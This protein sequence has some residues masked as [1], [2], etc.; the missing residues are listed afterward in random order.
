[1]VPSVRDCYALMN[2]YG[3][4]DNIRDHSVLVAKVAGL[5]SSRLMDAGFCVSME[6]TIAGALLHDIGKTMCL[7]YG[8]DHAALGREICLRHKF[9]EIADIVGEHVRLQDHSAQQAVSEKEIVYYADKRVTHSSVVSLEERLSYILE[10][11]GRN[12]SQICQRIR[13]NFALCKSLEIK[14]FASLDFKPEDL[15]GII[16]GEKLQGIDPDRSG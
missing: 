1:M 4:L 2:G 13:E 10:Q 11:Y 14:L 16:E 12:S 5:I 7:E 15:A 3:M 9:N 8:G 6:K